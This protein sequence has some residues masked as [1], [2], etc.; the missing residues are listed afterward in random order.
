MIERHDH[1]SPARE[2]LEAELD[3]RRVALPLYARAAWRVVSGAQSSMLFVARDE[4]GSPRAALGATIWPV[5]ALPGHCVIRVPRFGWGGEVEE[6]T[7]LLEHLASWARRRPLALRCRVRIVTPDESEHR[8]YSE[9][10]AAAGFLR[11]GQPE[12]YEYSVLVDLRR[13]LDAVHAAFSRTTRQNIREVERRP[14][15][16]CRIDDTAFVPRLDELLRSAFGRTGGA[17]PAVDWPLLL[18]FARRHDS[19]VRLVGLVHRERSGP[20]ALLAFAMAAHHG[21]NVEYVHG[22]SARDHGLGR[23]SLNYALQWDL[24][25]WAHE[26]GAAWYDMGGAAGPDAPDADSLRGITEFKLAFGSQLRYVGAEYELV[27]SPWR[28]RVAHLAS[29][30]RSRTQGP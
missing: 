1:R 25:R 12:S 26:T 9:R 16:V 4:G 5:R 24:I 10:L 15:A 28:N 30:V 8:L 6:T 23:V 22:A 13:D 21:H 7:P 19:R 11:A 2:S 3:A 18:A 14:L 20:D 29:R 17:P 27:T